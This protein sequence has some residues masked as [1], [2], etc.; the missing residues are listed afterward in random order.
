MDK[1]RALWTKLRYDYL[2]DNDK[3]EEILFKGIYKSKRV[4]RTYGKDKA[5]SKRNTE[6]ELREKLAAA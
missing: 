4:M 1:L 2:M 5:R 6:F 3:V